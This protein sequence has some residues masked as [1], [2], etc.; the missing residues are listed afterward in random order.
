MHRFLRQ[1]QYL[2]FHPAGQRRSTFILTLLKKAMQASPAAHLKPRG[3]LQLLIRSPS[4]TKCCNLYLYCVHHRSDVTY[5][6]TPLSH[7]FRAEQKV[8]FH[9]ETGA[10]Y[11]S[12]DGFHPR[13][14][15][16]YIILLHTSPLYVYSATRN[17]S[18]IVRLYI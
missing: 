4:K 5:E 2:T 3:T 8:V 1:S 6:L 18:I 15:K 13:L 10:C 14:H 12:L 17:N 16:D 7:V 11:T 9:G